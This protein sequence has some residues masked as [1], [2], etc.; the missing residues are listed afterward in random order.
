MFTISNE[1]AYDNK[2][3]LAKEE[4]IGE[5]AWFHCIGSATNRQFVKEQA[6]FVAEKIASQWKNGIERPDIYIITPFTAVKDGIKNIVRARLK[7]EGI[8]NRDISSWIIKSI[9]TVHTFQGREADIVYF[10][11]GTD[12]KSDSAANWSCSKPN[13]INVAV[14]RAKEEFYMVGD[15]KRLS[16]KEYYKTIAGNIGEVYNLENSRY[17]IKK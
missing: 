13:L 4:K 5:S 12:E 2:M 9:G 15:Y 14:T 7:Q 16:K 3:V 17:V 11:A 6:Y 8:P 10:V 1:I